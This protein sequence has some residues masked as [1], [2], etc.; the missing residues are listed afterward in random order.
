[1]TE[2][3]EA[4]VPGERGAAGSDGV[5]DCVS[6]HR[7]IRGRVR[8]VAGRP[9]CAEHYA[10]AT[11]GSRGTWPGLVVMLLGLV[12]LALAMFAFGSRI[13]DALDDRWLVLLGLILAVVPT[14]LWLGVFR[15]LDRLEPEPHQYL[16]SVTILAALLTGTV[17][18]PLRRDAFALHT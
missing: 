18:E 15:E 8:Q 2:P 14:L 5:I 17:A 13:S 4:G 10:R 12:A 3:P 16:L 6:C 9:Y 7:P 1:M 11:L